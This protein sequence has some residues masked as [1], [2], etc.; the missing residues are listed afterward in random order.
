MSAEHP[1]ITDAL[2]N[3]GAAQ[4]RHLSAVQVAQQRHLSAL[5]AGDVHAHARYRFERADADAKYRAESE[6]IHQQAHARIHA[7]ADAAIERA[8]ARLG[9]T[10]RKSRN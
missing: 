9:I 5:D 8:Y 7:P 2:A 3:L 1:I 6:Y 4:Q 10:P